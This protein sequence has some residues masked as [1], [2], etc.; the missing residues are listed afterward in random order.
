MPE[1]TPSAEY[2]ASRLPEST[3]IL[4]R[5]MPS[6]S[7]MNERPLLASRQAAVASPHKL[8]TPTVS[9]KARKRP[10]AASALSTASA[11]SRPVDCT[12]RPSPAR[13]FS[14]K[15]GVGLRVSAS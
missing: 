12:S 11:G 2:L 1:V 4:A 13:T 7:A 6:A 15:I 3:S 9:H 10:S 8:A 5:Q 14:L